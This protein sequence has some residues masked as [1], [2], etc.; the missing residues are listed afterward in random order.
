MVK[1]AV[2][3]TGVFVVSALMAGGVVFAQ[4]STP[5]SSPSPSPT[6]TTSPSPSPTT[7]MPGGAPATGKGM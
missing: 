4:T 3:G 7:T 6:V 5:E 1:K 2:I